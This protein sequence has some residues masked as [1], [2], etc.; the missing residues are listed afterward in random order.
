MTPQ[1]SPVRRWKV[2]ERQHLVA[3]LSQTTLLHI[4]ELFR[5]ACFIEFRIHLSED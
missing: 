3:D 5:H 2:V 1:M 4:N